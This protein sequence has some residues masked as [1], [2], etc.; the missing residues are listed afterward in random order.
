MAC[1]QPKMTIAEK[2]EKA[3]E[4]KD[5]GNSAYKEGNFKV[6]AKNYHRAI[7]YLKVRVLV[8]F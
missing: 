4:F 2:L 5:V 6:A 1:A 8:N 3:L 7:V